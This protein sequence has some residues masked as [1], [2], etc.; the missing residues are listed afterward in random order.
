MNNLASF[1]RKEI[2]KNNS[3]GIADVQR[4]GAQKVNRD[5]AGMTVLRFI[6]KYGGRRE[7]SNFI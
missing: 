1:K 6:I 7:I 3:V 5:T 2:H 4:T